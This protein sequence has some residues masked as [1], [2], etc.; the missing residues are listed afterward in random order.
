MRMYLNDLHSLAE[1]CLLNHGASPAVA[2]AVAAQLGAAERDGARS[3]G[4]FRLPQ[5]CE[6]VASGQVSGSAAP[7][8]K[9]MA[10]ALLQ[11]DA[12]GGF[13][14]AVLHGTSLND[15]AAAAR[16]QGLAALAVVN[17]RG[18][19]GALWWAAELV[20][21]QGLGCVVVCNSPPFVAQGVVQP[22]ADDSAEAPRRVF[23]TNPLCFAWPR[24]HGP[25]LVFDQASSAV[26]RGELLLAA[27]AGRPINNNGLFGPIGVDETGQPVEATDDAGA[28]LRGAQ[29]P[30]GGYKGANVALMI[31]ILASIWTGSDLAIDM[32]DKFAKP[33][34]EPMSRGLLIL[35]LDPTA[36]G[37][38][39]HAERLEQLLELLPRLPSQSRLKFRAHAEAT[40]NVDVDDA[41]LESAAALA[42][43]GSRWKRLIQ[44]RSS[45]L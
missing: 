1:H 20:A 41:V 17:F 43:D 13:V 23:G 24:K 32:H 2:K 38:E 22:A 27:A 4:L 35:A 36:L 6:A 21:A 3:H 8:V 45:K 15:L 28:V 26:S 33:G 5:C 11:A 16:E 18:V 44:K 12:G 40:G 9:R 37:A 7:L 34:Q 31:E 10:P 25:P 19:C 42:A 30:F 14:Q 39:A 29:L